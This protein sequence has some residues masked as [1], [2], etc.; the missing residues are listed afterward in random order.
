MK[1]RKLFEPGT[2]VSTFT[3]QAG[4]IL[5]REGLQKAKGTY[6]EGRRPGH[7]FAPG[8]CQ[9]PDYVLQVPVLF[10]DS[11]FDIMRAM[12]I[13]KGVDVPA[14]KQIRLKSLLDELSG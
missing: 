12:N 3:G 5:S 6:R 2:F 1:Q 8:C 4:I 7:Y 9:N 13:R 10:E 14:E 11:T